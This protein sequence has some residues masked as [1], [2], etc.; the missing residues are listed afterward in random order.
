MM[1]RKSLG[2]FSMI[3]ITSAQLSGCGTYVPEI[4][5]VWESVDVKTNM[6]FRIKMNIFCEMVNALREVRQTIRVGGKPSIPDDYGVQMQIN[7]TVDEVGALNPS[8]GYQELL[9]NVLRHI[10]KGPLATMVTVPQ[11]FN[12]NGTGTLSSDASRLDT[13]YSYY[14]VGKVVS[15]VNVATC[16]NPQLHNTE[17]SSPLLKSNLGIADYLK[18]NVEGADVLAS[19]TP[20][21]GGAGKSAKYDVFSYDVKFII[22]TSGGINPVWK[23]V[24]IT[25][26][27]GNLP[28]VTA[29]RTRTHELILTFGPGTV[30]P[31]NFA[32]QT[33]FTNQIIQS[34]QQRLQQ[35]PQQ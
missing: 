4:A 2:Y 15:P 28:L 8:V 19:S 7:L 16:N 5:E 30:Q 27:T 11:S 34:N 26:G 18:A 9:P 13:V 10:V 23:L 20:A 22:V 17:G 12:L 31:A 29:G 35:L 32:L 33:H 21:S 24:N 14:N 3:A 6:E 25:A 1:L